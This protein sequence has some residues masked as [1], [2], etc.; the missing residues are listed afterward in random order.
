MALKLT[1]AQYIDTASAFQMLIG[2]IAQ[3]DQIAVDTESNNMYAY[4]GQVCL[5][6]LS[7]REQDYIIDPLSLTDIQPLGVI[8]ADERIEKIFHAAEYDLICLKRDFNFEVHNLFDTMAAARLI[9]IKKFGLGNLLEDYFGVQVDKSHQRDDWGKRPLPKDSLIYAQMDTHYLHSLRDQLQQSL[10]ERGQLEE[11]QEVFADV[12]RIDVREQSFDPHGFWKLGKP[13]RLTR[14]QMALLKELYLLREG[15]AQQEDQ[16]PFKVLSNK[17]LINIVREQPLNYKSLQHVNG[18]SYKLINRYGDE[19]IEAIQKG[20]ASQTPQQP[21]RDD[22]DPLLSERYITLHAWRKQ[23]AIERG[24]DSS[25]ILPKQTLWDIAYQMPHTLEE[26][27]Q[28]DG[29]GAWRLQAYGV[30]VLTVVATLE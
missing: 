14:R 11:A 7:T 3:Q 22:P 29:F 30:D 17:T 21:P 12:L 26:L 4:H 16:P 1:P 13:N 25:L 24:L 15:L 19:I 9:G 2:D 6:Q 20:R 27:K 18:L 8:L 23:R 28:I 5:I 10:T